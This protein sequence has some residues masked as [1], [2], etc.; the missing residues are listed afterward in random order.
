MAL[1]IEGD[2]NNTQMSCLENSNDVNVE[3]DNFVHNI[4]KFLYKPTFRFK[5]VATELKERKVEN[6][7]YKGVKWSQDGTCLLTCLEDGSLRLLE[8]CSFYKENFRSACFC[9]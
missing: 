4:H 2:H 1:L 8:L 6:N 3:E 9:K 5:Y 7:F